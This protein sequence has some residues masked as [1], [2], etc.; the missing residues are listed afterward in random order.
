MFYLLRKPKGISSFSCI[1]NF[2]KKMNIKKIG[3]SGTLDPL[4]S[5]LLLCASDE[6]TKLI[7]YI[8]H[9]SKT[10]IAKIKFGQQTSTYDA[11]GEITN[12]SQ[13]KI[14]SDDLEK[15]NNWFLEQNCQIPPIYSA[16]KINGTR[17]YQLA[18]DGKNVKLDNQNIKI[19][20]SKILN[21]D[22][23][24]QELIVELEVSYGTYIRSLSNDVGIAFNTY[25]YM[26]D[27]ERIKIG[28]LSISNKTVEYCEVDKS[29]LFDIKFYCATEQEILD[30]KVGRIIESKKVLEDGKYLLVNKQKEN[31]LILGILESKDSKLKVIKLFG[32]RL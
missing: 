14:T 31:S 18:R 1:R 27:L 25:S 32:N 26:S 23:Q 10:Y 2:A 24:K 13:V 15:I 28:D 20:S 8:S 6:D 3:H 12:S 29:N 22:Y 9:K 21:F 19:Y 16:K 11:E 4:A 5:G 7:S 30:L 17:S